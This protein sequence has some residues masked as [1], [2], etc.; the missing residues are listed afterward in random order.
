MDNSTLTKREL[1]ALLVERDSK[2]RAT[3]YATR[4]EARA[5]AG[6]IAPCGKSFLSDATMTEHAK[7]AA[8]VAG[9]TLHGHGP[10]SAK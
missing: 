6:H 2:P 10:R 5:A 3:A 8:C 7:S 4:D 1:I 9:A